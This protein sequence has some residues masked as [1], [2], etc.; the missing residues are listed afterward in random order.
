MTRFG[1]GV[2]VPG[3]EDGRLVEERTTGGGA[4]G[5]ARGGGRGGAWG[6]LRMG[7]RPRR[8]GWAAGVPGGRTAGLSRSMATTSDCVPI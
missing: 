8:G 3:G 1:G 4:R 5:G 7:G 6:G 2:D